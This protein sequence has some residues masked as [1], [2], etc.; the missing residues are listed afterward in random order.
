[1]GSAVRG[2]P[3]VESAGLV[4]TAGSERS[5]FLY[6]WPMVDVYGPHEESTL[7]TWLGCG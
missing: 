2:M 4:E 7:P 5:F 3:A 6:T 1:L